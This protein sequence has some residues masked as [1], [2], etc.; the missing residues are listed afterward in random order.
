MN[1]VRKPL[2]T[3]AVMFFSE[4]GIAKEM[5]YPEFEAL[6]DGMVSSPEFADETVE[7]VFLQ[8]SNRLHVRGAVFFTID[9]DL[10][11]NINSLWNMPLRTMAEKA[12]R[13]PDMGGGPIRLVCLGFSADPKFR[14]HLWKPGQREGRSDL[15]MIKEAVTRNTL[16]ILGDDEEALTVLQTDRLQ[17][18]AEDAWYGGSNV[19]SIDSSSAAAN[20]KSRA[21]AEIGEQERAAQAAQIAELH[22]QIDQLVQQKHAELI[23]LRQQHE[24]HL[25]IIQGELGD[26]KNELAQQQKLNAALKRDMSKL[27]SRTSTDVE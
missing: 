22:E 17:M 23:A 16:G 14:P 27:Q 11:G 24:D 26:I 25:A 4:R 18:A 7:A 21:A 9:F 6:L 2:L 1:T 5:L 10:D 20:E 8:I 19:V 3:E 15:L 12:G 13:G